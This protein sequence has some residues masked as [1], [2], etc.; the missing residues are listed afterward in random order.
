MSNLVFPPLGSLMGPAPLNTTCLNPALQPRAQPIHVLNEG[1][2]RNPIN[3]L[4]KPSEITS[5]TTKNNHRYSPTDKFN[6]IN[7]IGIGSIDDSYP[8]PLNPVIESP[9]LSNPFCLGL[10][11]RKPWER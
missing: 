11:K 2:N 8:E 1:L 3:R 6:T 10:I 7:K 5:F 9:A 4:N